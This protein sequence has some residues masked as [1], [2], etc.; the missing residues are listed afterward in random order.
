M[1][2]QLMIASDHGG[3]E[4]K[5]QIK[6]HYPEFDWLDLGPIQKESTVDY[7]DFADL[8]CSKVSDPTFDPQ[9]VLICGSGQG[10]S[11]RANKFPQ[12]RAAL[13]WNEESTRLSREHNNAN[14]LCLGGRLLPLKTALDC[15][16]VFFET[17]FAGGRHT[18]RVEKIHKPIKGKT[19]DC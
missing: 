1:K 11:I 9:G 13:V 19:D 4:L 8:L 18:A 3:W 7:P 16:K 14:I 15:V 17:P 2:K 5:E 6:Q 10:M 12:I